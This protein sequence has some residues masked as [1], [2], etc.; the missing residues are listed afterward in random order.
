MPSKRKP[1]FKQP[2]VPLQRAWDYLVNACEEQLKHMPAELMGRAEAI[3]AFLTKATN[4]RETNVRAVP[5]ITCN[6]GA[7]EY[8]AWVSE[9]PGG[10][11]ASVSVPFDDIW[12]RAYYCI[13][14]AM[15]THFEDHR[16][17]ETTSPPNR[18]TRSDKP[19]RVHKDIT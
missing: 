1:R 8:L 5:G 17:V 2:R 4:A 15:S 6:L 7:M 14:G 13:L 9:A 10:I 18:R 3:R 11:I 19:D 16:N 12:D